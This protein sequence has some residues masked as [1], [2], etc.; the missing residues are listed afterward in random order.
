MLLEQKLS[1]MHYI[2]EPGGDGTKYKFL[3]CPSILNTASNFDFIT[4]AGVPDSPDFKAYLY[5]KQSI[6][7]FFK[8][9]GFPDK[10]KPYHE[11]ANS[12]KVKNNQ[13]LKYI[14]SHSG[15]CN[16]FTALAALI[17]AEYYISSE[18]I[19]MASGLK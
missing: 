3:I 17:C 10:N 15:N 11:W 18:I 16:Y 2:I 12:D 13:Y 14:I 4:I 1:C 6:L 7:N 9:V 19:R 8:E 5:K